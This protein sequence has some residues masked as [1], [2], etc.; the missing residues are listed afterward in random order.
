MLD[1]RLNSGLLGDGVFCSVLLI[2]AAQFIH[3]YTACV[4]AFLWLHLLV[5]EGG[6]PSWSFADVV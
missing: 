5:G 1:V 2:T 3:K 4:V 6:I